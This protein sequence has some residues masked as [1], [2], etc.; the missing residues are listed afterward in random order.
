MAM[1]RRG[2]ICKRL[3]TENKSL[4]DACSGVFFSVKEDF[5]QDTHSDKEL[6]RRFRR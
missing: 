5:Y 6:E 1:F 3:S 4:K 2:E